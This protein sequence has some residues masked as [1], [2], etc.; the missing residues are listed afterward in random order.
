MHE[1]TLFIVDD[2]DHEERWHSSCLSSC[3]MLPTCMK[4]WYKP[5]RS[6]LHVKKKKQID[7]GRLE[8]R[9]EPE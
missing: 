2:H 7:S 9:K 1:T 8:A 3:M 5:N 6:S 4:L